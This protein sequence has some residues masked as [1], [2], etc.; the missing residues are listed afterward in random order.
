MTVHNQTRHWQELDA[1]H[2]IHPFS[3]TAALNKEGVRVI[4]SAKGVW[5]TDSEGKKL[6]D[7]MAGLWCVQ[8]GY[9]NEELAEAGAKALR[10]L[11]YYN[12]FFKTTTPATIELAAK[13][14][15]VLP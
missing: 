15:E 14:A 6:I 4:T 13:L 10:E 9:G 7:G 8:L 3:D 5:L 12:S 11:P 2:H 1:A